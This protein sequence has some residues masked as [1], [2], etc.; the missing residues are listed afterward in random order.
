MLK[1][2]K[3]LIMNMI[4]Y[5]ATI[6]CCSLVFLPT[7]CLAN[8]GEDWGQ[9]QW[10]G[11]TTSTTIVP[12]ISFVGLIMLFLLIIRF[13][14]SIQKKSKVIASFAVCLILI[15]MVAVSVTLPH[16][17]VNG[18]TADANEVNDN[19][20]TLST[21]I[22]N[23]PA[24]PEGPQGPAGAQGPIGPM[25]L[26]GPQGA[27]GPQ[28]VPGEQGL[29]GPQGIPGSQGPQGFQGP[30]GSGLGV[31]EICPYGDVTFSEP[32]TGE[33]PLDTIDL[34]IAPTS[35]CQIGISSSTNT[36]IET[37]FIGTDSNGVGLCSWGQVPVP[38]TYKS[39]T[40][41]SSKSFEL[42]YSNSFGT[43]TVMIGVFRTFPGTYGFTFYGASY[44]Y[45]S[46]ILSPVIVNSDDATLY[47]SEK[48]EKILGKHL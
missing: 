45:T 41:Y 2:I 8:W 33:I 37:R 6:F 31:G 26:V 24:G 46:S 28:G 38:G 47:A 14:N 36:C 19:F 29:Q 7:M 21:A 25:G 32:I 3:E 10:F 15:P 35:F 22:D 16:V 39:F 12:T 27:Q 5:T 42:S 9:F 17:F 40:A 13:N 30:P 18:E 43:G 44:G 34:S 4:R 20:N 23:I 11:S 1:G 48:I